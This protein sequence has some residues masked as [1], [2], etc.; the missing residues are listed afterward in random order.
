MAIK[1]PRDRRKLYPLKI[2][3]HMVRYTCLV[4]SYIAQELFSLNI[5]ISTRLTF[6]LKGGVFRSHANENVH[7][8]LLFR[9][10]GLVAGSPLLHDHGK[11]MT[12]ASVSI[13]CS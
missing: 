1:Q 12:I 6:K 11:R 5:L 13:V 9:C 8:F 10:G 3:T 7:V 2:S 4:R